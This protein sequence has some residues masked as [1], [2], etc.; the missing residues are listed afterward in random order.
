MLL[1]NETNLII[2][3]E[4]FIVLVD[5]KNKKVIKEFK[6]EFEFDGGLNYDD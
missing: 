3:G 5:V 6:Y 4:E 2:S 1:L